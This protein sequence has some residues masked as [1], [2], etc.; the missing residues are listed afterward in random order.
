[1]RSIRARGLVFDNM[2]SS[3]RAVVIAQEKDQ[4]GISLMEDIVLEDIEVLDDG[5]D[6]VSVLE[7]NTS[8][9]IMS[10][11][12]VSGF[13]RNGKNIIPHSWGRRVSGPDLNLLSPSL[14]VHISGNVEISFKK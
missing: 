3:G 5:S 9:N 2:H 11:I 13:R 7:I 4:E 6:K 14:D 10:G 8:G 1:M 12:T